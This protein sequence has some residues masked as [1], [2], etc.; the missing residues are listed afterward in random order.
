VE[1][2]KTDEAKL[3]WPSQHKNSRAYLVQIFPSP[4]LSPPITLGDQPVVL[5]RGHACDIALESESVSRC[6]ARIEAN[7]SG[8]DVVDLCSTNGTY[9]NDLPVRTARLRNG[10]YLRLGEVV[11]RFL[12]GDN[13]EADYHAKMYR[14]SIFDSLTELHNRGYLERFLER[15]LSRSARHG[16]PL[17]LMMFDVDHFKAINDQLGHLGG[18]HVLRE[19]ARC[20]R[21]EVRSE[22]M[23]A[24]YGGDE[25]AWVLVDSD[26]KAAEGCAARARAVVASHPF[27]Y[28]GAKCQ[29]T[30]STGVAWTS[31]AVPGL[32]VDKLLASADQQ[33]YRA[34]HGCTAVPIA[35]LSAADCGVS[36]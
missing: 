4:T 17:A 25:F 15:E 8:H 18:D 24:R 16:R 19:L 11:F 22:E 23:L 13:V 10:D 35:C 36:A 7:N 5:G 30:I 34:K 31:G 26:E 27:E 6:H 12:A 32:N 33:L 2:R 29:V 20:V 9:I 1:E 28:N 3:A 21:S 14:L